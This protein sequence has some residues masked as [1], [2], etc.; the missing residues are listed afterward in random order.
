MTE[1][2]L[3][4]LNIKEKKNEIKEAFEISNLQDI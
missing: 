2:G 4:N 3:K 1:E